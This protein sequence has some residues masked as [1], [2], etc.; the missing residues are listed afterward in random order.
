MTQKKSS[1]RHLCLNQIIESLDSGQVPMDVFAFSL[2]PC[3]AMST[4]ERAAL[5]LERDFSFLVVG[6]DTGLCSS[7]EQLMES[8]REFGRSA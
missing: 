1:H 2:F 4:A 5:R 7:I 8:A 6:V 3:S